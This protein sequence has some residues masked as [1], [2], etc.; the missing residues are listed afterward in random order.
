[1]V[2]NL[3][4]C[5][6]ASPNKGSAHSGSLLVIEYHRYPHLITTEPGIL[7]RPH[8]PEIVILIVIVLDC[9]AQWDIVFADQEEG[10]I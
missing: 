6:R 10:K 4:F 8:A 1:M 7:G 3:N 9:C 5:S 2:R